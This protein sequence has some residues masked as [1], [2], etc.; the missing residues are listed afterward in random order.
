MSTV[1]H[2]RQEGEVVPAEE[3]VGRDLE[4]T[5]DDFRHL[6]YPTSVQDP[7]L[8]P[9]RVPTRDE[10]PKERGT[11]VPEDPVE[12]NLFLLVPRTTQ[13]SM[14]LVGGTTSGVTCTT[15]PRRRPVPHP[16]H[17]SPLPEHVESL[18]VCAPQPR[19]T[20][21]SGQEPLDRLGP[22]WWTSR[23]VPRPPGP[24]ESSVGVGS[25]MSLPYR[26]RRRLRTFFRLVH[27]LF[28]VSELRSSHT[29]NNL[30]FGHHS[31][32]ISLKNF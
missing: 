32:R 1:R 6:E 17:P 25:W 2:R 3:D 19:C 30:G 9:G 10:G 15:I 27:S 16:S 18:S 28:R 11:S 5:T 26:T 20:P 23:R 24:V 7:L 4:S 8:F 21:S 31:S 13:G 12:E 22:S 29:Q 14:S